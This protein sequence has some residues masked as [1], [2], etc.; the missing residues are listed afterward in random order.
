MASNIYMRDITTST[1]E[2][3][4]DLTGIRE[5]TLTNLDAT[6]SIVLAFDESTATATNKCTIAADS[7]ITLS[8]SAFGSTLYYDASANTPTL[9]ITGRFQ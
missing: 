3:Y 5:I 6:D 9:R 7:S 2:A 8:T 4:V 1:T